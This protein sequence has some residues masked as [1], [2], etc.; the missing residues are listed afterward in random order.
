[1][2]YAIAEPNL[3]IIRKFWELEDVPGMKENLTAE[4]CTVFDI[5]KNTTVEPLKAGLSS[6]CPKCPEDPI[7][8]YRMTRVTSKLHCQRKKSGLS[9]T[10]SSK[11]VHSESWEVFKLH[12]ASSS[13]CMG[14]SFCSHPHETFSQARDLIPHS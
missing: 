7:S 9:L 3:D 10:S 14:H 11:K 1:M 6:H 8:D 13:Y 4:E 12:Q 2:H 5:S